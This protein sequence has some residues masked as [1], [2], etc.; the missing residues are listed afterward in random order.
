MEKIELKQDTM[1][2]LQDQAA[3]AGITVAEALETIIQIFRD[4]HK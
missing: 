1:Q 2:Y 3:Q 4:E